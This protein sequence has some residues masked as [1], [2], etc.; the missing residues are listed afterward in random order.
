[1][2]PTAAAA[3]RRP[4]QVHL[5]TTCRTATASRTWS[6]TA[7][8]S[9]AARLRGPCG[10]RATSTGPA[11]RTTPLITPPSSS[12]CT[13]RSS[14]RRRPRRSAGL[15]QRA[16]GWSDLAHALAA[17]ALRLAGSS[18]SRSSLHM[19]GSRVPMDVFHSGCH[20]GPG[21]C[22]RYG[23]ALAWGYAVQAAGL[24]ERPSRTSTCSRPGTAAASSTQPLARSS[25]PTEADLRQVER[26]YETLPACVSDGTAHPC[27]HA[28]RLSANRPSRSR[29]GLERPTGRREVHAEIGR[30]LRPPQPA[31]SSF[32]AAYPLAAVAAVRRGCGSSNARDRGFA[33]ACSPPASRAA[34]TVLGVASVRPRTA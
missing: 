8:M 11:A 34:P 22:R 3:R 12:P 18:G 24:L 29:S 7:S 16:A 20:R 32:D 23:F 17:A 2:P 14:T 28:E 6:P 31:T 10:C 27:E 15:D 21:C 25:T 9:S 19:D 33:V 1:M 13:R 4:T 26:R 30:A 5:P